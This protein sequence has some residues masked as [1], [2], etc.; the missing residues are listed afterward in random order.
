[1]KETM[2]VVDVEATTTTINSFFPMASSQEEAQRKAVRMAR[3]AKLM[4][5]N[6]CYTTLKTENL[7]GSK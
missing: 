7:S 6:V 3:A 4:G 1:M 2:Y 5:V